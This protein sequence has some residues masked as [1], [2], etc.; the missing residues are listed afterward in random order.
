MIDPDI[1]MRSVGF[2][3]FYGLELLELGPELARGQLVVREEHKQ[4]VG[5]VHGGVYASMAES[6]ASLATASVVLRQGSS[7][8]GMSNQ[9]SFVRPVTGGTIHAR[10]VRKHAGRTTWV[11]EVE[12][13]DDGGRLCA[14][15]RVTV[16]VREPLQDVVDQA[17]TGAADAVA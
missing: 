4:P 3:A 17:S 13:S 7:A 11:W 8:S 14:L 2:D 10:G 6:L 5:L 1:F 12:M 9:T 15:S 16:A